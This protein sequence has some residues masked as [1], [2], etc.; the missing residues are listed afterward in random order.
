VVRNTGIDADAIM[1]L[2]VRK[3]PLPVARVESESA[4]EV[5][6]GNLSRI[7]INTKVVRDFDIADGKALTRCRSVSFVDDGMQLTD[8]NSNK[9]FHLPNGSVLLIV[10]GSVREHRSEAS[11]ERKRRGASKIEVQSESISET[12]MIDIYDDSHPT[13]FRLSSAGFDFSFLGASKE[14]VVSRNM[15]T[16]RHRIVEMFPGANFDDRYDDD[17]RFLDSVW[18]LDEKTE[19]LGK[20]RTSVTKSTT[21]NLTTRTNLRQF[22]AYSRLQRHLL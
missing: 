19:S 6:A 2:S 11:E 7:G 22:T 18:E 13:G 17:R 1:S 15:M 12:H 5:V 4:A 3:L 20:R 14:Y 8:F 10:A 21:V 16:L 9:T